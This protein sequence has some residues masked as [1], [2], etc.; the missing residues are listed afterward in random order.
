VGVFATSKTVIVGNNPEAVSLVPG[1]NGTSWYL[2]RPDR[3][4]ETFQASNRAVEFHVDD[5]INVFANDP[6]GPTIGYNMKHCRPEETVICLA[7]LLPSDGKR[8]ARE[9]ACEQVN[10]P[11]KRLSIECGNVG[12]DWNSRKIL[13]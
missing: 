12:M 13:V 11:A 10:S 4:A 1:I 2:R 3:V 9:A 6:S 5:P 7:S 8:L